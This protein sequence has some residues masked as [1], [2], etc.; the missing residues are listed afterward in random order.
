MSKTLFG[1]PLLGVPPQSVDMDAGIIHGAA[2]NR[3]GPAKG[4]GVQLDADFV[5]DV[6]RLGNEQG[7]A[8][9]KVR[10]GHPTMSGNALLEAPFIGRAKNFTFDG[11]TTRADIFL[12]NSAKDTPAGNLHSRALELSNED[13]DI[14][15]MSIV[16][17][18]GDMFRVDKDGNKF[19][20]EEPEFRQLTGDPFATIETLYGAD[21]VDDPAATDGMFSSIQ[22]EAFAVQA[23]EFLDTHPKLWDLIIESP[24]IVAEFMTRYETMKSVT[25]NKENTMLE[26]Q[27]IEPEAP[28]EVIELASTETT[29]TEAAE[30]AEIIEVNLESADEQPVDFKELFDAYGG[31]FAAYCYEEKLTAD[32]ARDAFIASLQDENAQLREQLDANTIGE[33]T[34]AEFAAVADDVTAADAA[35]AEKRAKYTGR[36]SDGVANFAARITLPKE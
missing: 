6:A 31:A 35:I 15:G 36:T 34:P 21:V 9:I 32:E 20:E 8:G 29:E 1:A 25:N 28:E 14:F 16:F 10:F 24:G 12:S 11:Q 27:T 23:S 13:P 5:A 26:D 30:P 3:V 7:K 33:E 22:P 4:H 17:S 2:I 19:S 18:A